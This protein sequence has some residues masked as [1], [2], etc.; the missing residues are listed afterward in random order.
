MQ[1]SPSSPY[2]SVVAPAYNEEQGIESFVR[3]VDQK[4]AALLRPRGQSWEIVIVDDGSRDGTA[5]KVMELE[6]SGLPVRLLAQLRPSGG[7]H[8]R[9]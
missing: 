8:G 4:V 9:D 7:D 2:L 5:Q 3:T 1:G 6:A